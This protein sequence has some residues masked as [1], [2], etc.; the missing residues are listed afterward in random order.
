MSPGVI[1]IYHNGQHSMINYQASQETGSKEENVYTMWTK[2][3]VI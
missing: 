1:I 2:K 3:G